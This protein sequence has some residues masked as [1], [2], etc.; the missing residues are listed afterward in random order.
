MSSRVTAAGARSDHA[1]HAY[2]LQ[3]QPTA[4]ARSQCSLLLGLWGLIHP[5]IRMREKKEVPEQLNELEA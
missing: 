4:N 2:L 1:R 3:G 5:A